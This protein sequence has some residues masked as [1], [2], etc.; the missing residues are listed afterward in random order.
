MR[1]DD[2]LQA[3]RRG[4]E[5]TNPTLGL[6]VTSRENRENRVIM[7]EKEEEVRW[8]VE[9]GRP[10]TG[11]E[12]SVT[13][14]FAMAAEEVKEEILRENPDRFCMFPL[15]YPGVWELYKQAMACFWT[16]EEVDLA[17]DMAQWMSLEPQ[18]RHFI[19]HVLAFFASSDG[20]V[21]EVSQRNE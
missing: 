18:E 2:R 19:K 15:R 5:R 1:D 9:V 20:I 16:C 13:D 14:T 11:S 17:Q 21:V 8:G 4:P 10:R 12:E 7:M 3:A 6:G